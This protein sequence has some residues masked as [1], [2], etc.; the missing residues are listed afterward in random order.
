MEIV[1]TDNK[2]VVETHFLAVLSR[3]KGL[4]GIPIEFWEKSNFFDSIGSLEG[5]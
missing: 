2:N 5:A 3:H 4:R 1:T